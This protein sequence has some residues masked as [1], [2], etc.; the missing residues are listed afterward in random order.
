VRPATSAASLKDH[1]KTPSGVPH[2][3]ATFLRTTVQQFKSIWQLGLAGDLKAGAAGGIINDIAIDNGR[4]R[5]N[6]DFRC[7]GDIT[8]RPDAGKPSRMY[9]SLF[10]D[11]KPNTRFSGL[12]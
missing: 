7:A 9:D 2:N 5:I 10:H 12:L 6:Y 4:S 3:P 11:L 1:P 8:C